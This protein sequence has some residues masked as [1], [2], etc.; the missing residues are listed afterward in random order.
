MYLKTYLK[1][2]GNQGNQDSIY[3]SHILWSQNYSLSV[4]VLAYSVL[5]SPSE[6]CVLQDGPPYIRFFTKSFSVKWM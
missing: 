5:S 4:K 3:D 6:W 1:N 2:Q